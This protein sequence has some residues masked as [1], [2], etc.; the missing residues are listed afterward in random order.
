MPKKYRRVARDEGSEI[1]KHTSTCQQ[2]TLINTWLSEW[3]DS[4]SNVAVVTCKC[5]EHQ[6]ELHTEICLAVIFSFFI[7]F[8]NRPGL[9]TNWIDCRP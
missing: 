6:L 8:F 2:H 7:L 9:P 1:A 4:G 5:F 3:R